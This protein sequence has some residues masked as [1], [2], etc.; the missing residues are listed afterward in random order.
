MRRSMFVAINALLL[1]WMTTAMTGCGVLMTQAVGLSGCSAMSGPVTS[2]RTSVGLCTPPREHPL[3]QAP[4]PSGPVLPQNAIIWPCCQAPKA[5][6]SCVKNS[7]LHNSVQQ[8]TDCARRGVSW[9]EIQQ[10]NA[11][12]TRHCKGAPVSAPRSLPASDCRRIVAEAAAVQV[13]D[14]ALFHVQHPCVLQTVLSARQLR[15]LC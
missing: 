13:R 11:I 5:S 9:A 6:R 12:C 3:L 14:A 1:G 15:A 2:G 8:P 10:P 4:S 7:S